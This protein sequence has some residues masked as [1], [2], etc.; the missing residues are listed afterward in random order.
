MQAFW[1]SGT[2]EIA[3]LTSA[4]LWALATVIYR[5]IGRT[6]PAAQLNL[7]KGLLAVAL[8]TATLAARGRLAWP[9]ASGAVLLLLASGAIGIGVGDTLY[10]EALQ[11]VGSRR[12][13][14][15]GILAPPLA[16]LIAWGTL[17]EALSPPAW[18]GIA[19]AV[20]GVAW[21]ITEQAPEDARRPGHRLRGVAF[22]VS[23][24]L[25]QA[26]GAVISH[27]ALTASEIDVFWSALLRLGA[28]VLVTVV[29]IAAG[30]RRP[31]ATGRRLLVLPP[32][33]R[34]WGAFVIAAFFGTF[35]CIVLQQVALRHTAAGIA[36]TL[37][38]TSPLFVLPLALVLGERVTW[39]AAAG[40][41]L[42]LAG[43]ALLFGRAAH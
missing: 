21:V 28:G 12:A 18:L 15:L 36:Q 24:A 31:G 8:L 26:T 10:F 13:L 38:S 17:G 29:W 34:S 32:T 1:H 22:G 14:L 4:L 9:E 35:I 42:A 40:A 16:A 5:R 3:A 7:L 41:C 37:M 20:L 11:Y 23:A 43:V 2:G 27:Q 6:V 39:R 30:R 33:A 19:L 25:M